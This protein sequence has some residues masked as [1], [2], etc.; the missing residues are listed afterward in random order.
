VIIRSTI[1]FAA[2]RDISDSST[3]TLVEA[4]IA[5]QIPTIAPI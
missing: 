3:S 4:L 1:F 5:W 2:S